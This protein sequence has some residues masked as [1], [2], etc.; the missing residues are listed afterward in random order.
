M[1]KTFLG[2]FIL[3]LV[4]CNG[5]FAEEFMVKKNCPCAFELE[6]LM[7]AKKY[8]A[9]GDTDQIELMAHKGRIFITTKET[10]AKYWDNSPS[11][12]YWKVQLLEG[13]APYIVWVH[14]SFITKVSPK[15]KK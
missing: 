12:E 8:M 10:R 2:I 9:Q 7:K 13:R 3:F 11:G 4:L 15:E 1:K 14:T 6:D 5:A